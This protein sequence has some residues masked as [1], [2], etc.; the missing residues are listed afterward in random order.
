MGKTLLRGFIG[1][2]PVAITVA[3]FVWLFNELEYLFGTPILEIFGPKYYFPGLG[4]LVALVILYFLGLILNH[5]VI[6]HLYNWF[7]TLLKKIPLLKTIYTSVSDLMSFFHAGQ[8]QEKDKVV[9]IQIGE[10]KV[11]GLITRETFDDLPKGIGGEE[12]VAVFFPFSY[13]IGGITAIVPR[14]S[15]KPIDFTVE[16]GLRWAVT[17][18]NPSADKPTYAPEKPNKTSKED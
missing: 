3:L 2:A 8:K 5:W 14:S 1:I 17:A 9:V 18:G 12:D 11:I 15:I 10:L 6:Q 16:K 4:V 13:Q 7:E